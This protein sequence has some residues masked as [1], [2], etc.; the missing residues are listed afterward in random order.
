MRLDRLRN[1]SAKF[2]NVS[3]HGKLRRSAPLGD[4]TYGQ[5]IEGYNGSN[6][7]VNERVLS[8]WVHHLLIGWVREAT[9]EASLFLL[10]ALQVLWKDEEQAVPCAW[11]PT[12]RLLRRMSRSSSRTIRPRLFL[13][14]V[15]FK[16]IR[17]DHGDLGCG[18]RVMGSHSTN[19]IESES[20][21]RGLSC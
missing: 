7:Q 16:A 19:A 12:T 14:G 9:F 20:L 10:L 21:A 11:G 3:W 18:G 2:V 5:M 4:W 8:D 17:N 15:A 6:I 13:L 1:V